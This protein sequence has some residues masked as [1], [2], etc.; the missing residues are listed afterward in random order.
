LRAPATSVS[1]GAISSAWDGGASIVSCTAS[2]G[3]HRFPL[4]SSSP[5]VGSTQPKPAG[6]QT[7]RINLSSL[8]IELFQRITNERG[9]DPS[10]HVGCDLAHS[11]DAS[12]VG[13]EC[14]PGNAW[15]SFSHRNA[16][17][18]PRGS[19]KVFLNS[20]A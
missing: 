2:K 10:G 14:T 7:L 15:R 12:A 1:P 16:S 5:K 9:R 17:A 4:A 3:E 8:S 13:C 19:L 18:G 6:L 11:I 20:S